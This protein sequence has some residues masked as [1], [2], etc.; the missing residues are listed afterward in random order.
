ML[1]IQCV[2]Y[3]ASPV[4]FYMHNHTEKFGVIHVHSPP[5]P[6]CVILHASAP[7]RERIKVVLSIRL[8]YDLFEVHN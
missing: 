2:E 7:R 8:G 6:F 4:K 3:G 1:Q 5:P